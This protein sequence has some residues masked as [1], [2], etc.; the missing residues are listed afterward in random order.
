MTDDTDDMLEAFK[1]LCLKQRQSQNISDLSEASRALSIK[2]FFKGA[3]LERSGNFG[4][5][6]LANCSKFKCFTFF[7]YGNVQ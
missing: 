4:R 3:E 2:L 1:D 5:G 6:K 7:S